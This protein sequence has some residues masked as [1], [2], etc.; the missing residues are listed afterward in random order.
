MKKTFNFKDYEIVSS[1][2]EEWIP[3]GI[4]RYYKHRDEEQIMDV[5]AMTEEIRKSVMLGLDEIVDWGDE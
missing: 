1:K 4:H 3:Y 2:V 5:D